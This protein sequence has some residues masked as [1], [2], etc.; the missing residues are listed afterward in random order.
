MN[1]GDVQD[2]RSERSLAGRRVVVIGGSEGIGLATAQLAAAAGAEVIVASR[3]PK[4]LEA[5]VAAIGYGARGLATDI[6]REE[7]VRALFAGVGSFDHL[8][9]TAVQ[10]AMKPISELGADEAARTIDVKFWGPF[11]AVKHGS[12]RIASDGS[13]TLFGGTAAHKPEAG[14]AVLAFANAGVE[15]F[16]RSLAVEL[17]PLRVN[18]VCPGPVDTPVW[19]TL[20]AGQKEAIFEQFRKTLPAR[21]VGTPEDIAAAALF[22]MTNRF[23]TGGA[24]RLDGGATLV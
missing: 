3:S 18:C 7:D 5:A 24:L 19:G 6:G 14:G 20:P 23:L 1:S 10:V 8:V 9:V 4:K 11:F 2:L 13:I 21:R 22:C 12:P 16:V 15:G 17:A